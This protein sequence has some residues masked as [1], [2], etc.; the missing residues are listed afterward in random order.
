M[1]PTDNKS[2]LNFIFEQM[3]KLDRNEIDPEKAKTQAQLAKEA[4]N[5]LMYEV[6]RAELIL[7]ISHSGVKLDEFGKIDVINKKGVVVKL[8]LYGNPF[9]E[10]S[11]GKNDDKK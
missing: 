6:K 10:L 7:K 9:A 3:D 8:P 4:N 5:S 2:L 1:R 11:E